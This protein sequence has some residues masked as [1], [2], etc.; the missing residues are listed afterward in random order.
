M[1]N[2]SYYV[3]TPAS[4]TTGGANALGGLV[5]REVGRASGVYAAQQMGQSTVSTDDLV[6]F[7]PEVQEIDFLYSDGTQW[8]DTWDSV[9]NSGLPVAVQISIAIAPQHPRNTSSL[10][11]NI[12]RLMVSIPTAKPPTSTSSTTSSSTSTTQPAQ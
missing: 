5:R 3:V 7:A 10:Q 8:L 12:Y 1:K 2:V 9:S 4:G 11:P 6:P